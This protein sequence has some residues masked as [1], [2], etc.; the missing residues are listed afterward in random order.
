MREPGRVTVMRGDTRAELAA[1]PG[2]LGEMAEGKPVTWGDF[3]QRLRNDPYP[4]YARVRESAPVREVQLVDGRRAWLVTGY[5]EALQLLADPRLS[6]DFRRLGRVSE[7]GLSPGVPA[8]VIGRSMLNTDP[9]DHTRLRG[10]VSRAFTTRRVESLRGR[11]E[12]IAE[13]LLDGMSSRQGVADLVDAFALPLPITVMGELLGV[14][15]EDWAP[16][17]AWFA[18]LLSAGPRVVED[19]TA[20]QAAGSLFRHLVGLIAAKRSAPRDDLLSALIEAC[21]GDQRLDE[22]ELLATTFLLIVAGHETT[23]NLIASAV[24]ALLRTPRQLAA[25]RSDLSLVPA[26]VEELLRYDGPVHHATFRFTT[27]AVDVGGTTIP[28]DQRVLVALAAANRDPTRF[29]DPDALDLV[30]GDNRHLG[31]GH[32]V[33]YCLGAPLARLECQIALTALLRRFGGLELAVPPE[34][35]TWR[36]DLVLRGLSALPVRLSVSPPPPP[37]PARAA[38]A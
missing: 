27:G 33:H 30:R 1:G 7:G 28:A 5:E 14:P 10:L 2:I 8:L 22:Q 31:F 29:P 34:E 38:P 24:V 15:V 16:L 12:D 25:L 4:L 37:A 23:V 6:K 19:Q 9:P 32:G 35:L 13:S 18:T 21:D 20:R 36:H 3:D 17:R 11:I 26:A